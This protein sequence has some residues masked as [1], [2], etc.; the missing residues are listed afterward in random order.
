LLR[1]FNP[2]SFLRQRDI[3]ALADAILG[4]YQHVERSYIDY[5]EDGIPDE[6][7]HSELVLD[8]VISQ[9]TN[10]EKHTSRWRV[11]NPESYV[12]TIAAG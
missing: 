9:V 2:F 1:R 5:D 6:E 11:L 3:P 8:G 12:L 7:Q 4:V 10:R